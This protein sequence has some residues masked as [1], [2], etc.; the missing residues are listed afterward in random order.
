VPCMRCSNGKY[1]YGVHGNCNFDTLGQ[2]HEAE[3]AIHAKENKKDYG[4]PASCECPGCA[5][6]SA[7]DAYNPEL[8]RSTHYN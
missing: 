4:H 5:G 8:D 1:K 6:Y 3:Q 2:C 7:S